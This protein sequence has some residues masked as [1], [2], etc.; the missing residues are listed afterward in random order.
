MDSSQACLDRPVSIHQYT[1]EK[2]RALRNNVS[3]TLSNE[4]KTVIS[5][6]GITRH[7]GRRGGRH[8]RRTIKVLS[9]NR[10]KTKSR[11]EH[12]ANEKNL[13]HV[14]FER[15]STELVLP[16]VFLCNLRSI[17]NKLDELD[18]ILNQQGIGLCAVTETW[19]TADQPESSFSIDGYKVF[20]K[21]RIERKG[22]G[23]AIYVKPHFNPQYIDGLPEPG[24]LEVSWVRLR[25]HRLPR[26]VNCIC[27]AAVYSPPNDDHGEDLIQYLLRC[28]DILR[29]KYQSAGFIILGDFNR[30]NIQQLVSGNDMRQIVNLHV[31]TR[32]DAV[33]DKVLTNFANLYSKP[34]ILSPIGS[35]DHNCVLWSPKSA[36]VK[37]SNRSMTR[38][39]RPM[40]ASDLQ[41]FGDWISHHD[42]AEVL[43]DDNVQSACDTFYNQLD[44][45]MN[46]YFPIKKVKIH[47]RD[48]PW[49][50]PY[51]KSLI[52]KRQDAFVQGD[53]ARWK[54][55]RNQVQREI[56]NLK[57]EFYIGR[58]KHLKDENP[59]SWYKHIKLLT[60]N[61]SPPLEVIHDSCE[62]NPE[63]LD[64]HTAEKIKS[65]FADVNADIPP[66][67]RNAL[68]AYLPSVQ[69]A[70][71]VNVWQVYNELKRIKPGKSGGPDGIPGRLIREFAIFL[72]TPLCHILNLSYATCIVPSCWKKAILVP[73]PKESPPVTI[74]NLRPISLTDHFAKIAE[75]FIAKQ[76]S[77]NISAILDPM[78]YGCRTGLSTTHY[79]V[80][81]IN[82]LAKKADVPTNISTV[83][84][85]DFKKA[86]DRVSHTVVIT[87]LID[88]GVQPAV[89][90][91]ICDFLTEREYSVRFHNTRS[92][93]Q[94]VDAGV[95]QGTRLL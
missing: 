69:P 33:L 24:H 26:S 74:D 6:L 87:K 4:V 64:A 42:W 85:T 52:R 25:P 10:D 1:S 41:R 76:V 44:S 35:L 53:K 91:W 60:G 47:H 48:K 29:T 32:G 14:I 95:P 7:R 72:A 79:L 58:V 40:K 18:I 21:S 19:L 81:F 51:L 49:V 3:E 28:M 39:I 93:W 11:N 50:T 9:S 63:D 75:L 17:N 43:I 46:Q 88:L 67:D 86:F 84:Y 92:S 62:A 37:R 38:V 73:L 34:Q 61:R 59:A 70:K 90:S 31:P 2:L 66:L 12:C 94:R 20:T 82:F 8:I 68:P 65:F 13:T 56:R 45:H 71:Q 16:T 22:G 78:Q 89:I 23:V 54:L 55:L 80:D 36:R 27:V 5:D 77:N 83:V 30:L 57:T 15:N